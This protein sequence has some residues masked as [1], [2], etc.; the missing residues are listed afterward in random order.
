[1]VNKAAGQLVQG[2][3]TGDTPLLEHA[4][5]YIKEKYQKPGA[6]FLGLVHRLD[7]PTSGVLVL[8]RTSKALTRLNQQF[9]DRKTEKVYLAIVEGK[10]QSAQLRLENWLV[11]NSKQN[12]SY[13]YPKEVPNSKKAVLTF[14]QKV[15]MDR[16]SGLEIHLETG[17]HHQIRAQLS[18]LG[19]PIKGDLKYNAKR[20]NKEG[21]IMLH[22]YALRLSHPVKKEVMH[23]YAPLPRGGLWELF[24][25]D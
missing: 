12:K 6:V 17:R 20:S 7:R 13:A 24:P 25:D 23:F 8:A 22:S 10:V 11:R 16:Y 3:H 2:D 14:T 18:A 9:K 19:H 15:E 5:Q 21:N 4:K 1:M